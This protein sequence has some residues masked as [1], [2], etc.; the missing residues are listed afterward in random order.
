V[1]QTFN[2]ND[3]VSGTH[4]DRLNTRAMWMEMSHTLLR[5]KYLLAQS[6]AYHEPEQTYFSSEHSEAENFSWHT[7][8]DKMKR[9][10]LAVFMIGRI[11]DH[12][13]R[14][15]FERLGLH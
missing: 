12:T 1:K 9:F 6:R 13:A 11:S 7:H 3:I 5:A 8:L 14:L 10:D 4:E 2:R 15:I